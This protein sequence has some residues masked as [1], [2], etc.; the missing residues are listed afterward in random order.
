LPKLLENA[1]ILVTQLEIP[2]VTVETVLQQAK[3]AGLT[4]VLNPAP[5]R[6]LPTRLAKY[7]DYLIPNEVEATLLSRQ[8]VRGLRQAQTAIRKLQQ[9][10]YRTVI[11]T[12]GKRGLV[13]AG[14]HDPVHIPGVEVQATDT[15]AAGDTFVGY[16]A[17]ALAEGRD[18]HTALTWAN[19]AAALSVTRAGAMTSMPLRQEVERW[20]QPALTGGGDAA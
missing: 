18:L 17:C 3:Q 16:F 20:P 15:T 1:Q 2:L 10:G 9:M 8:T 12:L 6:R 19:T 4:T 11:I 7:V 14:D 13:Y 5:A